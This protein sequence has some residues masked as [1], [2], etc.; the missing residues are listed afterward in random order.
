[1]YLDV[2]LERAID[3]FDVLFLQEPPWQLIRQAPSTVTKD[4]ADVIE[5]PCHPQWLCMVR[6]PEPGSRPRVM[7]YVSKKLAHWRPAYRRDLINDRDVMVISLFGRGDPIH[8]MNVYSDNQHQA[9]NLIAEKADNM[10]PLSYMGGDFN[11][12]SREWDERVE[13]H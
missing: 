8:L 7:T 11:C 3:D 2:L 9:I 5:A 13:H 1:M 6:Q 12:H 4:G 10:P